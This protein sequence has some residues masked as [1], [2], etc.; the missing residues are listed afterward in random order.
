MYTCGDADYHEIVGRG[1]AKKGYAIQSDS[2]GGQWS[3]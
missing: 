3:L 1:F 2:K